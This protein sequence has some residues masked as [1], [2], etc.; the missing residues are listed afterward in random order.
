MKT[1]K[2]IMG[3]IATNTYSKEQSPISPSLGEC[4]LGL[5]QQGGRS[6]ARI[7]AADVTE[8]EA[9][10]IK[11]EVFSPWEIAEATAELEVDGGE[12]WE[13]LSMMA[14]TLNAWKAT[15]GAYVFAL[16]ASRVTN[17]HPFGEHR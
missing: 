15:A 12:E 9:D 16:S 2:R 13:T 10:K 14:S 11:Q 6:L 4:I 7:V 8:A 17:F 1:K 3:Y 5:V